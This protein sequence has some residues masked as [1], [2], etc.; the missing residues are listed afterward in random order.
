MRRTA[1]KIRKIMRRWRVTAADVAP[2]VGIN[3]RTFDN[4]VSGSSM[5]RK[6][7]QKITDLFGEQIWPGVRPSGRLTRFPVGTEIEF[8]TEFQALQGARAFGS[9]VTVEGKT[10][11]FA[12]PTRVFVQF[13]MELQSKVKAL[14]QKEN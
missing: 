10:I 12:L 2:V 13:P 7:R 6:S 4:V 11:R 14:K 3:G 5:S 8:D 9:R 1:V